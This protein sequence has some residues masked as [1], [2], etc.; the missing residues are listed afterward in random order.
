MTFDFF[1]SPQR[2][3]GYFLFYN[4]GHKLQNTNHGINFFLYVISGHKFRADLV[5]LFKFNN[6]NQQ[7]FV[8][9]STENCMCVNLVDFISCTNKSNVT[10][11]V[12]G[13]G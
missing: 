11:C 12:L 3:A 8:S 7:S 13:A 9:Q 2:F 5:K 4:V 6:Q 1:S 10:H